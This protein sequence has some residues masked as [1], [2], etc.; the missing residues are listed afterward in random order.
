VLE[1]VLLTSVNGKAVT[2]NCKVP[3]I[4]KIIQEKKVFLF[5]MTRMAE[6]WKHGRCQLS[7]KVSLYEK[8]SLKQRD[9]YKG[10]LEAT[11][12]RPLTLLY[13]YIIYLYHQE[14]IPSQRLSSYT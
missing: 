13:Q 9:G 1:I 11:I 3:N 10:P 14:V 2:S 5:T 6:L 8:I 7:H 4:M 12:P